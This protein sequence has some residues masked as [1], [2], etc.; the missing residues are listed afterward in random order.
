MMFACAHNHD[1]V[2]LVSIL[3]FEAQKSGTS[4]NGVPI[5]GAEGGEGG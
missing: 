1:S 4:L 5:W 2:P 3:I